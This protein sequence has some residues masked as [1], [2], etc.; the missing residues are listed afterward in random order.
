MTILA[1][2]NAGSPPTPWTWGVTFSG[3]EGAPAAF[4]FSLP[5]SSGAPRFLSSLA[6]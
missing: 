4:L 6:P 5:Y 1:T 3:M 2:D